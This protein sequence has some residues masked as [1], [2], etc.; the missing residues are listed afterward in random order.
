MVCV[1]PPDEFEDVD[2]NCK[3]KK[4]D[5]HLVLFAVRKNTVYKGEKSEMMNYR[6]LAMS[7]HL[8]K[9][10]ERV[11]N[12]HLVDHLENTQQLSDRQ[13]GFRRTRGTTE[14]LIRLQEYMVDRLEKEKSQLEVWN[15]DLKK[16]V[17]NPLDPHALSM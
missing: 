12:S 15:F 6:P 2:Q 16:T 11:I 10:W 8:G 4:K 5:L 7:S 17:W 9:I 13:Y 3:M 14:N 1:W